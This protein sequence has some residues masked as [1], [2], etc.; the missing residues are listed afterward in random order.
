MFNKVFLHKVWWDRWPPT[1]PG[2]PRETRLASR[3]KTCARNLGLREPPLTWLPCSITSDLA[4]LSA[5]SPPEPVN[6]PPLPPSHL[7]STDAP[8]KLAARAHCGSFFLEGK[9]GMALVSALNG[10]ING[11]PD[12]F[13]D[14]PLTA[15]EVLQVRARRSE[16]SR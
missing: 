4:T 10:G 14:E 7:P 11:A 3:G 8:V 12:G 6:A 16:P 9:S 2:D 5:R 1:L 13:L 15:S